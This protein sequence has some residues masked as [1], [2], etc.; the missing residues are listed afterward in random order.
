MSGGSRSS[1]DRAR[2]PQPRR[3]HERGCGTALAAVARRRAG[4][5]RTARGCRPSIHP[6]RAS[7]PTQ[8]A[9]P[10]PHQNDKLDYHHIHQGRGPAALKHPRSSRRAT[11]RTGAGA[12]R[13]GRAEGPHPLVVLLPVGRRTTRCH[14]RGSGREA[15][16]AAR[17]AAKSQAT[18]K[19]GRAGGRHGRRRKGQIRSRAP[20]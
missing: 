11:P 5:T 9:A 20:R 3:P 13:P 16:M 15:T 7:P 6:P 1:P 14:Q 12:A 4:A 8:G 10:A 17:R 2:P 18:L 19:H